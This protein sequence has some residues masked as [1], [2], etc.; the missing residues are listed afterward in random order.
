MYSLNQFPEQYD[1]LIQ[2][3]AL[4][5]NMVAEVIRWQTPLAY[6]RRTANHDCEIGGKSIKAGDQMLMWYASGNR[7][8][9]VF[10]NADVLDIERRNARQHLSFGFGIHRCMGNRTAELQLKILWEEIMKRF[11]FIEVVGEEERTFS[12]FVRG[13]TEL[14]VRLHKKI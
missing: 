14:P 8:A 4:I 11:E 2:K 12:S 3:P 5:P 9:E 13:Y 7:D 6:M 10:D 1:K